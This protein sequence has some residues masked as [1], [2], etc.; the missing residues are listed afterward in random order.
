MA[1]N[2]T[3]RSLLY[4][5]S[6]SLSP[7]SPLPIIAKRAPGT[8]DIAELGTLWILPSSNAIWFLTSVVANVADWVNISGGAATFAS[9]TINPGPLT[10]HGSYIQDTGSFSFNSPLTFHVTSND[11]VAGAISLVTNGGAAE[12]IFINSVQG[13][14]ATSVTLD[15]SAGGVTLQG[16]LATLNAIN[17]TATNAA[18]GI[19][20]TGGTAGLD[21]LA[22]NGPIIV[23]SGTG[24]VS[25]STDGTVNT[26][27]IGTGAA[28]KTVVVGSTTAG[29]TLALQTPTGVSAVAANGV[30]VTTA[31]RGITLPGGLVIVTGAGSPAGSVTAAQGSLYLN[32]TGSGVSDRLWVNT[33][34]TTGWTNFVTAA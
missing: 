4:G 14:S 22:I 5:I 21:L 10:L 20:V 7:A 6:D 29:S 33:N 8:N 9:V 11:N 31:G 26:V 18:G 23:N 32:T 34:G 3:R 2:H 28:A 1:R 15:S 25:I 17:L 30:S 24:T 19:T 12:T 13:T 16:G 27:D